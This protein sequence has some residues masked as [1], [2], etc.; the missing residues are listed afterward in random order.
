M[1]NC[2]PEAVIGLLLDGEF[3][4]RA[5]TDRFNTFLLEQ[6]VLS[7]RDIAALAGMPRELHPMTMLQAVIPL[8]SVEE[9]SFGNDRDLGRG[10]AIVARLMSVV[11][12]WRCREIGHEWI[13]PDGNGLHANFLTA[14]NG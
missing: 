11:A 14:F 13:A 7:H 9:A 4:D 5:S 2:S 6:S 12:W 10:H 3:P 1:V 8:L